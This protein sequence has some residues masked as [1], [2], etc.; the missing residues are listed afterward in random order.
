MQAVVEDPSQ[1]SRFQQ[2]RERIIAAAATLI[3]QHGVKGMTFATVAQAVDMNTNSIAYYFKRKELLASAAFSDTLDR[4]E[5]MVDQAATAPTPQA[6]VATHLALNFAYRRRLRG[7]ED[8]PITSLSDLRTMDDPYRTELTERYVGIFRKVRL[9]F[10]PVDTPARK[11]L[12]MARAQI[13]LETMF[14]L[15]AWLTLYSTR[16]FDRVEARLREFF[17]TGV[18]AAGERLD[19]RILPIGLV[20]Q[21]ATVAGNDAYLRAATRLINQRG[22]R[23]ASVDRIASELNLTKGSFYHHLAAKDDLVLECFRRSYGTVSDA[24]SAAHDAGGSYWQR[25]SA[26]VTTLLDVQFSDRGPLLRTTALAA[27]PLDLRTDVVAR[28]NRMARRFAGMMIDGISEGSIRAIDP[29]IAS[30]VVMAMLN[31]AF[32][33]RGW[34]DGLGRP[35]AI[36]AYAAT[37]AYGLFSDGPA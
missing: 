34:A 20:E 1:T 27:L 3:N 36:E 29:L 10:G 2:R 31:A 5:A 14:W 17:E 15:P 35:A 28:S 33:L 19:P 16:E 23:G 12:N 7:G 25:L 18:A 4:L 24:Q 9:F 37:L 26:A 13:L 6:R 22:Y 8:R 30:Q 32:E 11:A 21:D